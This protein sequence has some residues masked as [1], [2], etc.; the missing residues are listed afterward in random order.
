MWRWIC[1]STKKSTRW[2]LFT[3]IFVW[4]K[5]G[6]HKYMQD[7]VMESVIFICMAYSADY[8]NLLLYSVSYIE[9]YKLSTMAICILRRPNKHTV[10]FFGTLNRVCILNTHRSSSPQKSK[11]PNPFTPIDLLRQPCICTYS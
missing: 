8:R 9:I 7:H 11:S 3:T 2:F 5:S 1:N 10:H 6:N 4:T